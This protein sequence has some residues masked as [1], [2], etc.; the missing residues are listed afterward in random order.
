MR[1]VLA[2]LLFALNTAAFA[3][4]PAAIAAAEAACG[5][6]EVSFDVK[7]ENSQHSVGHPE[8]GKALVYVSQDM[9]RAKCIGC[10]TTSTIALDGT[11]MGANHRSSNFSFA[12]DPAN[13]HLCPAGQSGFK[14]MSPIV[15]I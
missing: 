8:T 4:D 13:H 1:S 14:V 10:P 12:V 9:G 7:N 11:W 15:V 2:L 3:Q 6:K 5:P